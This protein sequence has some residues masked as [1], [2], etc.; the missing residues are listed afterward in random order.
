MFVAAYRIRA[1]DFS[2]QMGNIDFKGPVGRGS[3]ARISLLTQRRPSSDGSRKCG[4][5]NAWAGFVSAIARQLGFALGRF[6]PSAWKHVTDVSSSPDDPSHPCASMTARE[7]D[8]CAHYIASDRWAMRCCV[9]KAKWCG[10]SGDATP[11]ATNA[12]VM[13]AGSGC[14]MPDFRAGTYCY[15]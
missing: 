4:L 1:K 7:P 12:H 15:R 5:H 2:P 10:A 13:T 6:C 14:A 8:L 3:S 11:S 9:W